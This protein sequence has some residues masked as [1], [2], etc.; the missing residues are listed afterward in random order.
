MAETV[1][2]YQISADIEAVKRAMAQT[3]AAAKRLGDTIARELT[4]GGNKAA[5]ALNRELDAG[6]GRAESSAGR[7]G[8]KIGAAFSRGLLI[9]LTGG[10]FAYLADLQTKLLEIGDLAK[11]TGLSVE[12]ISALQRTGF[13]EGVS[14]D[15]IN[16]GLNEL[17][18][19]A[20]KEFREGEGDL[21][22]LLEANNLSLTDRNG[23]LKDTNTLLENAAT[24]IQNAKTEFDKVD[25]AKI[26]GLTEDWVKVLEKGPEALRESIRA[27]E[28][29]GTSIDT[30]T[31]KKAED[32][33]KAWREG[34][35]N[36][37]VNAKAAISDVAAAIGG[38][39]AQAAA[40]GNAI[41]SAQLG[42]LNTELTNVETRLRD[43]GLSPLQRSG[44]Q[45][46]RE[47]LL[48][49]R[50][51]LQGLDQLRNDAVPFI[52]LPADPG[53]A[54]AA[55][56]ALANRAKNGTTIPSKKGGGGG[57]GSSG[58]SDADKAENRLERYTEQLQRQGDVLKA[59]IET[60]GQ[61]NAER[62]A[63]IEI[64][65]AQVDLQKVDEETRARLTEAITAQVKAN[66]GYRETLERQRDAMSA[67]RAVGQ[68][69]SDALG[70]VIIDGRNASDVLKNL[71]KSFAR[72]AL[73]ASLSGSGSF[74]GLFGTK[75]SG[76]LF[77][78]I[79]TPLL[80]GFS[81]FAGG[82]E[83]ARG[84]SI[85]GEHG[86]EL[87]RNSGSGVARVYPHG[88]GSSGMSMGGGAV[89]IN[90]DFRGAEASAVVG[91]RQE[92]NEM[93]KNFGKMVAGANRQQGARG[94]A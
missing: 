3:E 61:S 63:A 43:S 65:K 44:L 31:V 49:K 68:E 12:R 64:A 69:F 86:P 35:T 58:P 85:V 72:Q 50:G 76:G 78:S 67:A 14:G 42:T 33:D 79:L 13:L 62:K 19:K 5:Q 6:M 74:A 10:A 21:K 75:E 73:N 80:K 16:K 41:R 92:L 46:Q 34:W 51:G 93:K 36:F 89:V 70:D 56:L 29:V 88:G 26:F 18:S 23:K 81:G 66:E 83:L 37:Q 20:N 17:G 45:A 84:Y 32:F 59:E 57:G 82:G 55:A 48:A 4:S 39:I 7:S 11:K 77:G 91:I 40:L 8:S 38:L 22:G 54:R 52:P 60:F 24:L 90:A 53:A 28:E 71:L 94:F 47:A 27:A 2:E 9:G 87:L 15:D 1:V 25:I 30:N